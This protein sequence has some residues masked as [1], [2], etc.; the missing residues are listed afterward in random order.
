MLL[1]MC[2]LSVRDDLERAH[3][4]TLQNQ[5]QKNARCGAVSLKLLIE[6]VCYGK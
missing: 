1:G 4:L 3:I 6:K 2:G 5:R